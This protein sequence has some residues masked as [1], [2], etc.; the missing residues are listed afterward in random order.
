MQSNKDSIY[1][2]PL[3][4]VSA[5]K[6]DEMVVDVFPD[7]IQRSVP[8][9]GVIISAIG[10][11]AGRF[12][13]ENSV[14]YDLGCSLGEATLAMQQHIT[15]RNCRIV[16]VD[17]SESMVRRFQ[18]NLNSHSEVS[19]EVVCG[20]IRNMEIKQASVV[21]LNFTLQFIPI[22]ERG[23]LLKGIYQGL[24]PGGIL[25]LSEKLAFEDV[26]QQSLQNEMHH[27][28]KKAQGYSD[29]EISQK[30]TALENVLI[31]ET[32]V[33]HQKRLLKSGF[34]NVEVW[35]QYFNFASMVALK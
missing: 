32:F 11:L 17:S 6:F 22:E 27:L 25:I 2:N 14:C 9:Y 35:F 19:V 4:E 13:Q 29:L 3:A 21:V 26:R 15:A 28:F 33:I 20:D 12:G 5:F 30:R 8:G 34:S 10:M 16:A 23:R 24:L 31:P 18:Q 1:A 7:M